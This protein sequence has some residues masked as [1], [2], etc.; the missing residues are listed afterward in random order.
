M[1]NNCWIPFMGMKA[2]KLGPSNESN[3]KHGKNFNLHAR[4]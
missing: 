1:Y 2:K 3:A 4:D